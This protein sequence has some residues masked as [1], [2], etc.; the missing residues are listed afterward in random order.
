MGIHRIR[1]RML[2]ERVGV[3]LIGAGGTGSE[4]L[5]GLVKLNEA[6]LALGHPEGLKVTVVDGDSV[7]EANIGRQGFWPSD[8][9][10]N[11][12]EVLINRINLGFGLD[13][14]A[15][16]QHLTMEC[17]LRQFDVVIGCVDSRAARATI[18]KC[19]EDTYRD[20]VYWLDFGNR[21]ADGQAI[22]GEISPR[23][24]LIADRLPHAAD[25]FPEIIDP[26]QE[27]ATDGPS[28]SLA[29]ALEKQALFTNQGVATHGLA[30]LWELFRHGQISHHGCFVNMKNGR[31]TPLPIDAAAWAR[32]GFAA[33]EKKAA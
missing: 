12:A 2:H 17:A 25:L 26:T 19:C 27:S 18:L 20:S 4:V 6:L 9:G 30:L 1:S 21:K 31:V 33:Q 16:P 10:Q 29:D 11:K 32:F 23:Y 5:R 8:V 13:W 22:L 15:E 14:V 28:C 7:S 24:H 3:A